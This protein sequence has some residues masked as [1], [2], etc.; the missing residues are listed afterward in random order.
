MLGSGKFSTTCAK[1]PRRTSTEYYRPSGEAVLRIEVC[2]R[3]IRTKSSGTRDICILIFSNFSIYLNKLKKS[4]G[5]EEEE[6]RSKAE[7]ES[8]A[9]ALYKDIGRFPTSEHIHYT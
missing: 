7:L 5:N 1:F 9:V 3:R 8:L 6:K 4:R 2:H